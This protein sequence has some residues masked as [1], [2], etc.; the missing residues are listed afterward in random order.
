[1]NVREAVVDISAYFGDGL[2]LALAVFGESAEFS[3]RT[4]QRP[5]QSEEG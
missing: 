1:M 2:A 4:L 5:W 3:G